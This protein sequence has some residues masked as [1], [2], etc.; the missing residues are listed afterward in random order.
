MVSAAQVA[1]SSAIIL[2]WLSEANLLVLGG[3]G[4]SMQ[5]AFRMVLLTSATLLPCACLLPL[6]S[7]NDLAACVQRTMSA[8]LDVMHQYSLS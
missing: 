3:M 1:R 7:A 6:G 4:S 2:R 5:R 8:T